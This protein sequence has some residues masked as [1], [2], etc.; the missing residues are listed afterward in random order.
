MS[1]KCIS[2][3]AELDDVALYC[4]ECGTCQEESQKLF[5]N[6]TSPVSGNIQPDANPVAKK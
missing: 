1:K 4:D 2:C 5:G 6:Q 3:G